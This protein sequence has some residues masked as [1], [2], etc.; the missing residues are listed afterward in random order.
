[1][2]LGDFDEV[3]QALIAEAKRR[4]GH[5]VN[6]SLPSDLWRQRINDTWAPI[7]AQHAALRQRTLSAGTPR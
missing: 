7:L 2:Q 3:R 5:R 4:S 6:G 1:L